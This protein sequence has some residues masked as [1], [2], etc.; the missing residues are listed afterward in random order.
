MLSGQKSVAEKIVYNAFDLIKEQKKQEPL[1]V[2]NEAIKNVS[3][4]VEVKSRRVGGA[5]YQVP[6]EVK[7]YRRDSLAIRWLV[8]A[9]RA[10]AN[11]EFSS[12]SGKLTAEII[13]AAEN[14]GEAVKKKENVMKMAEANRAFAHF[15]W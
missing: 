3:P 7:S 14:Q 1:D 8:D 11:K 6:I 13:A 9:A 2:F 15:K 10:R 5:S 4:K 12:M